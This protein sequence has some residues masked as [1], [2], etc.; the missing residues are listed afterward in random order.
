MA[1][2][3]NKGDIVKHSTYSEES[4]KK[5]I[6]MLKERAIVTEA[7]GYDELAQELREEAGWCQLLIDIN[8]T[9]VGT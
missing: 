4:L 6:D 9:E 1:R 7:Q 8:N 5:D 3:S 2:Q